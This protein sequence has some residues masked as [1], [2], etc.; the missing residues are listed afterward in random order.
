MTVKRLI[1][2]SVL[3][4]VVAIGLGL[5]GVW[6]IVEHPVPGASSEAR[7]ERLG[8][9]TAFLVTVGY[10]VLWLPFAY[11]VGQRRRAEQQL[12][13]SGHPDGVRRNRK[14]AGKS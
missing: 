7:S 6:Y 4:T 3:W 13:A 1:L 2:A 10:A 12:R 9:A 11:K 14:S 8:Q 5:L